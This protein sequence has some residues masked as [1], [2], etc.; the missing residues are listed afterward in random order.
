MM[1]NKVLFQ[2]SDDHELFLEKKLVSA[3]KSDVI[4]GSGI[5]TKYYHPD[6]CGSNSKQEDQGFN[7]VMVGRLLKDKGVFE[8]VE[9]AKIIKAKHPKTRFVLLGDLDKDNPASV[10]E[11]QINDWKAQQLIEV[12]GFIHDTRPY[13]C[14]ADAVVLPSYREGIPRV[15][16]EGLAMGKPCIT[17]DA[18]GCRH[19]VDHMKT[20]LICKTADANSLA[21][22]FETFILLPQ[23]ERVEM[24]R[25]A[26]NKALGTFDMEII[27]KKYLF[28]VN[29][30]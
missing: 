19:T 30:L 4:P 26:R 20:G 9:A 10:T 25:N 14:Q 8:Y 15:I 23:T 22:A 2:N 6:F 18:P 21:E 24:G 1:A 11:E 27:T 7:F 17:T 29:K 28:L 5:D 16:L 12:E 13:I 3:H